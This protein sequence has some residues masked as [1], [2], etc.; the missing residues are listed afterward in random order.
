MKVYIIT[1][2]VMHEG[3][4]IQGVYLNEDKAKEVLVKWEKYLPAAEG[5]N[6]KSVWYNLT[7][8]DVEE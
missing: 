6:R 4:T 3:E 7:E 8:Y 5:A 2:V 1:E